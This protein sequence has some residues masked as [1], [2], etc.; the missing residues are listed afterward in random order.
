MKLWIK[1][2]LHLLSFASL[3]VLVYLIVFWNSLQDMQR[4]LGFFIIAIT[5]HEWE[6]SRFPGGFYELM[7]KKFNLASVTEEKMGRAHGV[8]V[9]AIVFF[10]FVPFFFSEVA[11]LAMVPAV[12]GIFEAF[13]HVVGIK[14]HHLKKPY[15][16]GMA[17]ALVCMLPISVWIICISGAAVGWWWFATA[18]YYLAVFFCME[19]GTLRAF[20]TN[21]LQ[22][23]RSLRNRAK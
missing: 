13:I 15:T 9:L 19:I 11:W 21:P 22:V 1:Y 2:N 7:A 8:V 12:L 17:T 3:C 20:N 18:A 23:V 10:A 14:I 4:A 16:P 5:L 6:E